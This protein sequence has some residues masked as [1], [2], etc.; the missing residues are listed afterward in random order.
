[1]IGS[2]VYVP[3]L[4]EDGEQFVSR[5][6]LELERELLDRLS[7]LEVLEHRLNQLVSYFSTENVNVESCLNEQ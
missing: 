1:M 5:A 2:I 4:N 7:V 6:A 3:V